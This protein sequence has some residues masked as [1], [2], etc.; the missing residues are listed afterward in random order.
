MGLFKRLHAAK[1]V[2]FVR[3]P[4]RAINGQFGVWKGDVGSAQRVISDQ[5]QGYSQLIS[6]A[7]FAIA[8]RALRATD[9][10]RVG[11]EGAPLEAL[12]LLKASALPDCELPTSSSRLRSLFWV[13]PCHFDDCPVQCRRLLLRSMV[14]RLG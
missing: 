8:Y 2:G 7:S 13:C 3:D 4:P 10:A 5:R 1:M 6:M 11:A 9:P 14:V 12:H